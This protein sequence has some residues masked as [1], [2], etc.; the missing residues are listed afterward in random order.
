MVVRARR[1]AARARAVA[2]PCEPAVVTSSTP[3]TTAALAALWLPLLAGLLVIL[4]VYLACVT[5]LLLAGRRSEAAEL[6]RFVPDC[7]VL[8]ARLARDSRLPRRYKLLLLG[9]VGYLALPVDLVP[10]FLPIVGQLDDAI[11]VA[12]ALRVTL[13]HA[14]QEVLQEHWP[15]SDAGLR[16]VERLAGAAAG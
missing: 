2:A 13:R 10:D 3:A 5:A 1:G 9:L 7:A 15:G 14:G 4:A 11:L 12:F 8:F 6:A 16:M